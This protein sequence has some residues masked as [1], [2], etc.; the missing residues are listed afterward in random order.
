[1]TL[2]I[3]WIVALLLGGTG[4]VLV[5]VLLA[6][7][8]IASKDRLIARVRQAE[9]MSHIR[10]SSLEKENRLQ[11]EITARTDQRTRD[12]ELCLKLSHGIKEDREA[13]LRELRRTV[14]G[15]AAMSDRLTEWERLGEKL[16]AM[17]ARGDAPDWMERTYGRPLATL[18]LS[19]MPEDPLSIKAIEEVEP[20]D[21]EARSEEEAGVEA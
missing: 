7:R 16:H 1:M 2:T 14:V 4:G 21:E 5:A 11:R 3:H 8:K 10:A 18:L 12:L 19:R 15:V 20:S 17:F 13:E 6:A 9:A